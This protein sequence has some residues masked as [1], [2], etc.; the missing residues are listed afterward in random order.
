MKKLLA[1]V[2]TFAMVFSFSLGIVSASSDVV[3]NH[4][5]C[6]LYDPKICLKT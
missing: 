5:S 2:F 3:P 1:S 4:W 6:G